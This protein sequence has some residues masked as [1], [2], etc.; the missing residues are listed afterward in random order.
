MAKMRVVLG[1]AVAGAAWLY[2]AGLLL[3]LYLVGRGLFESERFMNQHGELG[4]LL[5]L[6]P[7][8]MLV[9]GLPAGLSR[10]QLGLVAL[11]LALHLLQV[12]LPTQRQTLPWLAALHPLNAVLQVGLAGLVAW[13]L[14]G[15]LRWAE[16]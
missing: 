7:M 13:R 15:R 3:V 14:A 16:G 11:L 6:L 1:W 12:N 9:L 2:L 10:G 8:L 4:F 5:G